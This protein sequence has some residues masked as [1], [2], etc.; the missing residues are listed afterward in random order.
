MGAGGAVK[1]DLVISA[2]KPNEGLE[3]EFKLK[4]G[5]EEGARRFI[6]THLRQLVTVS[7]KDGVLDAQE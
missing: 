3:K 2:Y 5:S 7:E 6:R 4:A 1:Q